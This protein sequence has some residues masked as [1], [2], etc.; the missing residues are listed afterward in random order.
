MLSVIFSKD[1][2]DTAGQEEYRYYLIAVWFY[3]HWQKNYGIDIYCLP[4]LHS[5][6][7]GASM[8]ISR[9]N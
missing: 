7:K 8:G 9:W 6:W 3:N 4:A 2:L 1:I 5:A